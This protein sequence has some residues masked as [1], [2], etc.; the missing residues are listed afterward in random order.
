MVRRDKLSGR[1][2]FED[3]ARFDPLHDGQRGAKA[4]PQDVLFG[5]IE[6]AGTRLHDLHGEHVV[7][8]A[9]P[10]LR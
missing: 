4:L 3:V 9:A 8:F 5:G 6:A 1:H 10:G 2:I 7:P